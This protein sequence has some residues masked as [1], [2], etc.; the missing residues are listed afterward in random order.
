MIALVCAVLVRGVAPP[1]MVLWGGTITV[2]LAGIIGP[3]EALSGIASESVLTIA[4][5]FVIAAAMRETGALDLIG[6]HVLGK[7]HTERG[8]LLRMVPKVTALSAFLANLSSASS[9]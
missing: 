9:L 8:A 6:A 2:T 3:R 5:L 1:D 7:A 4:A